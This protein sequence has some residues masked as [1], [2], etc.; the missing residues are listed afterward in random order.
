MSVKETLLMDLSKAFDCLHHKL[1]T[2]KLNAYSFNFPA[3]RLI[4]DYLS[5]RKPRIK[6]KNTYIT[7]M[8]IV[9]GVTQGSILRPL[10]FNIFLA[11]LFF[12]ISNINI[13]SYADDST[14][15]IAADNIDDLI[16]SLEEAPT[17]LFQWFDSSFLKN[18]LGKFHL[19]INK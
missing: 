7:W 6:I 16:K 1:I 19:L 3:L 17:A 2:A 18:N 14:S 11:G 12:I 13:A 5:N 4:H 15:Y 10:L 8:E 9:F